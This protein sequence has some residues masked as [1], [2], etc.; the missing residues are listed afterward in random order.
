[1]GLPQSR[2][3]IE[4]QGVIGLPGGLSHR[5]GGRMC[6]FVAASYHKSVK[7]I[8][9]IQICVLIVDIVGGVRGLFLLQRFY[10]VFLDEFHIIE[11]VEHLRDGDLKTP[12][13]A[14]LIFEILENLYYNRWKNRIKLKIKM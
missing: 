1:M 11:M 7:F 12:L 4:V 10:V 9:R 14:K 6:K 2:S 3:P 5:Q 13:F 8:F